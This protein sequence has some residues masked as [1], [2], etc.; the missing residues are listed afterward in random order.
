MNSASVVDCY[1]MLVIV[2]IFY[3]PPIVDFFLRL[4]VDPLPPRGRPAVADAIGAAMARLS[5]LLVFALTWWRGWWSPAAMSPARQSVGLSILM[6]GFT[7]GTFFVVSRIGHRIIQKQIQRSGVASRATQPARS[8]ARSVAAYWPRTRLGRIVVAVRHLLNPAGEE[9]ARGVLVGMVGLTFESIP[10]GLALGLMV[11]L[12]LHAYQGRRH[13][14][15]HFI[16][17][18]VAT[19]LLLFYGLASALTFHMLH[20][21][22]DLPRRQIDYVHYYRSVEIYNRKQV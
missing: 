13:L 9:C 20:S 6:G 4:K 22:M 14:L 2:A 12:G 1:S 10:L 19:S 16:F 5:V 18:A 7:F 17:F 11:N 3:M 21:F 8:Y 15:Y